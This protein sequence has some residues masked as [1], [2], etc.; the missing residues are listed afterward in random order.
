MKKILAIVLIMAVVCGLLNACKTT[1]NAEQLIEMQMVYEDNPAFFFKDMKLVWD[2]TEYFVTHVDD[3]NPGKEIGYA[4]D[5]FSRWRIFE[6]KGYGSDYLYAV[7]SEDVWRVMSVYPPEE[8]WRQYILEN[9]TEH[10]R[11]LKMMSVTLLEDG[12]ARLS[13]PP[14]SSYAMVGTYYY[15]FENEELLIFQERENITARFTVLSD[16]TLVFVSSSVPLFADSGARYVRMTDKK[17]VFSMEDLPAGELKWEDYDFPFPRPPA[18]SFEIDR[19]YATAPLKCRGI[20]ED[21]LKVYVRELSADGWNTI[22]DD[23]PDNFIFTKGK[24]Y[25]SIYSEGT[26]DSA[27]YALGYRTGALTNS[28]ALENIRFLWGEYVRYLNEQR[29][30][31]PTIAVEDEEITAV[32]EIG[33]KEVFEKTGMQIFQAFG[34]RGKLG[35]LLV[36]EKTAWFLLC[37]DDFLNRFPVFVTDIDKDGEFEVVSFNRTGSGSSVFGVYVYKFGIP[38]AGI[39]SEGIPPTGGPPF[40]I[41]REVDSLD[42][43]VYMAYM[44]DVWWEGP[45]LALV[46]ENGDVRLHGYSR[47]KTVLE[48]D[49]GCLMIDENNKIVPERY[50][51]LKENIRVTEAIFAEP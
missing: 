5:E 4:T 27:V 2:D 35:N 12:T 7:E 32:R 44:N 11:A 50:D 25:L 23:R 41:R 18:D 39:P 14:I 43:I 33:V 9:A 10:D 36:A 30:K 22:L 24:E 20:T 47:N 19:Q 8:P 16:N 31:Y 6:L 46:P 45:R 38:P 51:L 21:E 42:K 40:G 15:A 26:E 29:E 13:T 28:E 1:D 34:N 3:A 37:D 17:I 49:Y 48:E